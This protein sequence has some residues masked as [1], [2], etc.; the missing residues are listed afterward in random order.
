MNRSASSA[1]TSKALINVSGSAM[2]HLSSLHTL[3]LDARAHDD[4]AFSGE[5]EVFGGVGGDLRGRDEQALAP[6]AHAGCGARMDVD[7]RQE[8][9]DVALPQRAFDIRLADQRQE[10][11]DVDLIHVAIAGGD[12]DD[13]VVPVP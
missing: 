10:G 9:G 2:T 7:R 11:G 6:P 13:P 3:K 1:G 8:E 5:P 12:V 4:G